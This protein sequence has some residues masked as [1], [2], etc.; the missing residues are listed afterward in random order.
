MIRARRVP[1]VVWLTVPV[2]WLSAAAPALAQHTRI[3]VSSSGAEANGSSGSATVSATGRY[4]AFVSAATNLVAGDTNGVADV[5]VR[6]RDT[7]ADGVFDEPDAVGTFRINVGAGG[8]QADAPAT[9]AILAG[10]FVAFRSAATTLVPGTSAG[11]QRIFVADLVTGVVELASVSTA[12]TPADLDS[13]GFDIG[14]TAD[15][16]VVAFQSASR[17]LAPGDVGSGGA[18]FS[19]TWPERV[20]RRLSP[21]LPAAATGEPQ[22]F[23]GVPSVSPDGAFVGFAILQ[24]IVVPPG[25]APSRTGRVYR[26]RPDGTM[27]QDLGVGGRIEL[28]VSPESVIVVAHSLLLESKWVRRTL[29]GHDAEPAVF[30]DFM[31]PVP[32]NDGRYWLCFTYGNAFLQD[33][34]SGERTALPFGGFGDW[35]A[36]GRTVVTTMPSPL[37]P[38]A[39]QAITDVYAVDLPR[40]LD[41]DQDGLDDRWERLS[42]LDPADATGPNGP[43]GDP[44]G[45]GLSNAQEFATTQPG[46]LMTLATGTITRYFAEGV[47]GPF[48]DTEIDLVNPS[49][50]T[51]AA[52]QI[53]YRTSGGATTVQ[54]LRIPP[55]ERR[56]VAPAGEPSLANV[57]MSMEIESNIPV[58]ADRRVS[59]DA[60]GYGAHFETAQASPS[61]TWY[62][63]EGTTVLGFNLFYLLHNPQDAAV[64]ATIRYLRP[65]GP[66]IART[67]TLAPTSRL[68]IYVN[69]V[70]AQLASSDVSGEIVADRPIVVERAMYA[71]RAGQTFALGTASAGVTA[72]AASWFL[73][74]GATGAF[75]DLYVLIANPA[76][77]DAAVTARF[78]KPDGSVVTRQHT[79]A[80]N[81][82]F[83]I[84]VDGIE[85]LE[86]T[87]V[88]SEIVS[89]NGVPVT[90]ER[91]MYWPGGFFDYYEG[92]TATGVTSTALRWAVAAGE[93]GGARAAQSY[94]LIANP[95]ATAG[96]ARITFLAEGGF[97]PAPLLVDLPAASRVT[98]H[99]SASIFGRFGVLVESTGPSPVPIVV[100]GA[101]YWNAGGQVWAAG[102]ALVATPLP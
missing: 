70:D 96:Q 18:V 31:R 15:G 36:D 64:Q 89:A 92:H 101:F 55:R 1:V 25:A 74:E 26:L 12:G 98:V 93:S 65:S 79:V 29:A 82:R 46:S 17:V 42:G 32:S 58:V 4:V 84:F 47:T 76:P 21:P 83:S 23:V 80:A 53:R 61:T 97:G 100:E 88:S 5:F 50:S 2:L 63:T 52:V 27:L 87:P 40:L 22:Q 69:A 91:A 28:G 99:T 37:P 3:S 90:V 94:V 78:L 44:D 43:G 11:V 66:P 68:T 51:A 48:F 60:S 39:T 10:R 86:S 35:S 85:G 56:T 19:R 67:Y 71:S 9:G 8:A 30:F 33:F 72:P 16:Y 24:P 7:D 57:D 49:A 75:F 6:D 41:A 102:G 54:P 34:L 81:S 45:D 73:A 14:A 77:T 38:G 13:D 59:W 62:L 95:G 20:T